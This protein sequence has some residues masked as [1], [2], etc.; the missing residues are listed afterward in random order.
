VEDTLTRIWHEILA[1]PSGP[2]AFRFY[3]QP[4][5]ATLM[6]LRDGRKD[7]TARRPPY[8]WALFTAHDPRERRELLRDGWRGFR[9]IFL[10]AL[11]VDLIY[12]I[13]VLKGPRPITGLLLAITFAVLPYL[14]LR[15]PFSR[16]FRSRPKHNAR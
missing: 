4:F 1:R 10:M 8:L 15:G 2:L 16:M 12:Q 11:V 7:A 6:A 13:V 5:M 9:R 14:L 3:L